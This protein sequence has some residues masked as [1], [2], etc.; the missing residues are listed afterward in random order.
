MTQYG[1]GKWAGLETIQSGSA[2]ITVSTPIITSGALVFCQEMQVGSVAVSIASA[3]HIVVN[4]IVDGI[5]FA[6]ARATDIGASW[7]SHVAWEI[8]LTK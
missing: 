7:D 8:K 5:S 3:G 6:L 1:A 4:S 2:F